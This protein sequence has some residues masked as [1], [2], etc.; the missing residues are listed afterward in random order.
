ME[1]LIRSVLTSL[2]FAGLL[3]DHAI[4][5]SF[6][7][8]VSK[9][10]DVGVQAQLAEGDTLLL[11][12]PSESG[13]LK[14]EKRLAEQLVLGGME[15]WFADML[16]GY[17]LPALAS[18]VDAVIAE[19]TAELIEQVR[20]KSRKKIIL[21]AS[22]RGAA[23]AIRGANVWQQKYGSGARLAGVILI[24][25]KLFVETPE[26][27]SE[28]E[29]LPVVGRTNLPLFIIQPENSPWRWKMD[30]VIPALEKSGS[31]V[32]AWFLKN[33]RDRF[34]YRPDA[35]PG[36]DRMASRL[37]F[38]ISSATTLLQGFSEKK[39]I[40]DKTL[41][42][43]AIKIA[44]GKKARILREYKG[45]PAPPELV[46]ADME[47]RQVD[48]AALKGQVVLVN[49]WASWCPPCV[50]EMPSM[51]RLSEHFK[52]KPFR[53]LAV[54]MAEDKSTIQDFL[55]NKVNV[56]FPILL[57]VDGKALKRWKVFA[58]PT[59]YIIGKKGNI[60][61]ALFGSIDWMQDDVIEKIKRLI[62]E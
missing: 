60:R 46:L 61:L 52:S 18:S 6:D 8:P 40:I 49:Y 7:I 44:E 1:G 12:L 9:E 56:K 39:R 31:D 28:G 36:E 3:I 62:E 20:L 55:Q 51:Q 43:T 58:F 59:S 11:W 24:S 41:S 17:F 4:A 21:I 48:L 32:Y 50:H 26:P 47:G 53:I 23:M 27:G 5:S 22:G 30:R 45:N 16:G 57:D 35:T 34:Y 38:F 10:T 54:N 13:F 19:D 25:P 37:A 15:T 2:L 42:V 14:Q 33:A 29:L